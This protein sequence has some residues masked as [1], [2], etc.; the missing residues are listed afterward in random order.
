MTRPFHMT[1]DAKD[2]P[3]G[4]L[5]AASRFSDAQ[6]AA[7]AL[8]LVSQITDPDCAQQMGRMVEAAAK[9]AAELERSARLRRGRGMVDSARDDPRRGNMVAYSRRDILMN[10]DAIPNTGNEAVGPSGIG[11]FDNEAARRVRAEWF[12]SVR[13][14]RRS[15]RAQIAKQNRRRAGLILAGAAIG[16]WVL[17]AVVVNVARNAALDAVADASSNERL[18]SEE[19]Q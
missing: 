17:F 11:L 12:E 5:A 9:K 2:T 8:K 14:D 4:A 13:A 3:A 7:L 16:L 19:E 1:L 15:E 18:V 10:D 6:K